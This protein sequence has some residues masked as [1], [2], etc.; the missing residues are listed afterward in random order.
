LLGDAILA[1]ADYPTLFVAASVVAAVGGLAGW[2]L[3]DSRPAPEANAPP[4]RSFLTAVMQPH[5]R[6]LWVVGFGFAIA[7]ASY[8]TFFKTF[9][10]HT[11]VGSMGSFYSAYS[12][13]AILLRLLLGWVPD[14]IGPRRALA[15]AMLSMI[16]GLVV[17]AGAQTN[18][19]VVASGLLCGLG[20][21]FVFPIL[22]SLVV[23]RAAASERGAALAMFTALFDLGLL[24]GSPL[25]GAVL[26]QSSYSAMFTTAAVLVLSSGLIYAVWDRR[27]VPPTGAAG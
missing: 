22:S 11:G 23:S 3:T 7:I 16:G 4:P 26:E 21:A 15:P 10:E 5:L 25:L 13:A 14:R 6:P 1:H 18:L 20:H 12:A 8:F 9:V 24:V 27:A 2:G 19:A 17:L